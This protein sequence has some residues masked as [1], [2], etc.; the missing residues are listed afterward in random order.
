LAQLDE[1]CATQQLDHE[2]NKVAHSAL[3]Y[4]ETKQHALAELPLQLIHGDLGPGNILY[5]N[6]A[7]A[8][9]IDFTPYIESHWYALC[10]ALYW[11]CVYFSLSRPLDLERITRAIQI[12][13]EKLPPLP[14]E[15]AMFHAL[16]VKAAARMLF[17]EIIFNH[18]H[19]RL[20]CS[21]QSIAEK[22][23]LLQIILDA[24]Q[25]LQAAITA[26]IALNA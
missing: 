17:V 26:S 14:S 9:I 5:H 24:E 3:A 7:V 18:E 4:L 12:Y 19:S 11:H 15:V 23:M 22:V 6:D 25:M 13:A 1:L 16:F 21:K 2:T 8:A 10:V 20:I